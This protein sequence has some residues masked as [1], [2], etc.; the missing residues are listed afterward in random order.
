[1]LFAGKHPSKLSIVENMG[2]YT[3]LVDDI[4]EMK[5]DVVIDCTGSPEGL[6]MAIGLT[7]PRGIIVLKSTV[8]GNREL[9][10]TPL[11]VD[12]KT[13]IGSRC[14]YF[15]SAIRALERGLID[16]K[17]LISGIYSIK[18]GIIAFEEA[19]KKEALKILLSM[20]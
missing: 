9:D 13:L 6:E 2:I 16:V 18:D 15:P 1:L 14:G 12:E 19:D 11:V 4:V 5:A 3:S 20:D 7:R 17:P 8:A 10:L